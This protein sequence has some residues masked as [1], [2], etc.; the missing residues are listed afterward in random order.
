MVGTLDVGRIRV[1]VGTMGYKHR[2]LHSS[3]VM[4]LMEEPRFLL[5]IIPHVDGSPRICEPVRYHLR[6]ITLK[7]AW[8]G[9]S[10]LA[11]FP[12]ALAPVADLPVCEVISCIQLIADLTLALGEVMHDYLA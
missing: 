8:F 1:A 11:L 6:D 4:H 10:A 7:G 5:K 3:A 9:P 12:H 2:E